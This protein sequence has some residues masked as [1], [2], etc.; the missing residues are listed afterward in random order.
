[1]VD[2]TDIAPPSSSPADR[3]TLAG[4]MRVVL[5]KFLQHTDDMLPAK[6]IS[7]N[8]TTNLA[9]VQPLIVMVTTQ[10]KQVQRAP[11]S[12]IPVLQP[13][14]GG[15]VFS[16]PIKAGDLGWIKANDRDIS[17]FKQFFRGSPPN[18][19][20]KHSFEDAIFIPDCMLQGATIAS[21]DVNN[22]VWQNLAGTVKIAL[23]STFV[24]IIGAVG[25]GGNPGAG[26]L[27]G[28]YSTSKAF[29]LPVMTTG[30]RNSIASPEQGMMVYCSDLPGVS[31]YNGSM[32]S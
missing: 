16:M 12:A 18:T 19:Y 24:K 8:R 27:L 15:F 3:T 21:E 6:V 32:W 2:L 20:R 5:E 22:S 23:W 10:N 29:K 9:Q 30:Q 26:V 25:I 17:L 31:T 1:M 28:L 13:G 11:I 14:G 4:M 7:Y